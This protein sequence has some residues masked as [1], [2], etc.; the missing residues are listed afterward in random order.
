MIFSYEI[1]IFPINNFNVTE[2][3]LCN[4]NLEWR[5]RKKYSI[6]IARTQFFIKYINILN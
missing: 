4:A 1:L 6:L 5:G 2:K 3:A